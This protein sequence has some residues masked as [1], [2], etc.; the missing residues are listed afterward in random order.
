MAGQVVLVRHGET[1]WTLSGQH[2]S[3]TDIPLTDPGLRQA[4]ALESCLSTWRFARVLASP[5]QRALE[6]CRLAGLGEAAEVLPGL[7]EWD[8][9]EYEGRTTADIRK[10]R[11]GWSLWKDGV[12]GGETIHHVG[13]RADRIVEDARATD[14]DVAVFSHGHFLRV[15]G[16]RWIG[17][18]PVEGA[19]L[20][21]A[22]ASIS[23]LGYERETR[24]I[25][26]WNRDCHGLDP[27]TTTARA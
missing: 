12:P 14:G 10:E 13:R 27:L 16:A 25:V 2:T 11:P 1:E 23:V 8:Y 3:R 26:E 5:M 24:V 4:E 21:L 18:E 17:L 19:R 20:F 15:L 22:T 7:K 6:T 9:G